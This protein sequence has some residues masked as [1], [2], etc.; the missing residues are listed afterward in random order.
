MTTIVLYTPFCDVVERKTKNFTFEITDKDV[1]ELFSLFKKHSFPFSIRDNR[2]VVMNPISQ[3]HWENISTEYSR[4]KEYS[5]LYHSKVKKSSTLRPSDA[6]H[7]CVYSNKE[8]KKKLR[9][10]ALPI[11]LK[12]HK[13]DPQTQ[14]K[15]DFVKRLADRYGYKLVK[16]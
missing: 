16:K 2:T 4:F 15:I 5:K 7:S 11:L 8:L 1:K 10:L 9:E 12:K 14:K 6:F 13:M 3:F